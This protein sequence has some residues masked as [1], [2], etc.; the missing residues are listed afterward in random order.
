MKGF[1]LVEALITLAIGIVVASFL[2]VIM[3]N[4]GGLFYTQSSK[5]EQG[6]N[7]NDA[8]ARIKQSIKGSSSVAV[9]YTS[10]STTYTS[11]TQ[12]LV[13]K[14]PSQ[15][16]SG[17]NISNTFDYYIFFLDGTNLRFKVFPDSQSSRKGV[18]QIFSTKVNTLLFQYSNSQSPP[19]EVMATS[20][21]K[22]RVT[23]T[24]RQK[25]GAGFEQNIATGEANLINE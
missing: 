3:V 12:T 8:M 17:N 23:L 16:S 10:G 22:I 13:L 7:I 6:L 24:L 5:V 19:Q 21:V 20:A 2:L 18:D 15:D 14:V 9:S 4:T 11:G 25:A 1:T